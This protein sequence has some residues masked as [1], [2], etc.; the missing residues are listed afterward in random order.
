[1]PSLDS[2]SSFFEALQAR[3]STVPGVESVS[4]SNS[5]ARGTFDPNGQ[6]GILPHHR[7]DDAERPRV[8]QRRQHGGTASRCRQ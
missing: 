2:I 5:R 8:R 7:S 4:I 1:M 6:R 3:L